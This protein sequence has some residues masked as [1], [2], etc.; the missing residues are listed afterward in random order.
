M[1]ADES[2]GEEVGQYED[3]GDDDVDNNERL[4]NVHTRLH[5]HNITLPCIL[6][7]VK[8]RLP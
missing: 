1:W 7:S 2:E 4:E 8:G 3:S 5:L 6:Y